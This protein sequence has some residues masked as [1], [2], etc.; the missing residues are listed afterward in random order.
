V[1]AVRDPTVLLEGSLKIGAYALE[2]YQFMGIFFLNI[3][4]KE[5]KYPYIILI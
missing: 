4:L 5:L 3:D 1:L 2:T